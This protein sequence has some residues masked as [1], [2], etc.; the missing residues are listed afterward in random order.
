[1]QGMPSYDRAPPLWLPLPFLLVAPA[2]LGLAGAAL[3][4]AGAGTP[5]RFDP[6]LLAAT[7]LLALGVLGNA[8]CGSA[9]QIMAV[10]AGVSYARPQGLFRSLFWPLQLGCGALAWAFLA[11]FSAPAFIMA[12]AC[13]AYAL[14]GIAARGLAGLARSPSRD[15]TRRGMVVALLSLA[16]VVGLGLALIG[17]LAAAW[18]LP[19]RRLLDLHVLF[20]LGGWLLGL[21]MAVAVTVVPMF[22]IT[23]PYP[24]GWLRWAAWAWL[25]ALLMAACG[26]WLERWPLL[27]PAG[28]LA[29]AF[30]WLTWRLQARSRR[31]QDIGRRFWRWAMAALALSLVMAIAGIVGGA[32]PGLAEA[33]GGLALFGLGGGVVLGMWYKIVPFLLWLDLQKRAPRGKRA[34]SSLQLLPE[35]AHRRC[36]ALYGIA[37]GLGAAAV[38]GG[39]PTAAP[40][41]AAM[42]LATC[43]CGDGAA[44]MRRYRICRR[45][46]TAASAQLGADTP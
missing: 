20:A 27:L 23:P 25:A 19:W 10:V 6:A 18:P 36:L 2:W 7:H 45:C 15:A 42:V 16:I 11:G 14:L 22:Q 31:P 1:M 43:W 4:L 33:A 46:W 32:A 44:A 40:G 17:T 41:V 3:M 30:A 35:S 21:I 29:A 24:A 28:G 37:L 5:Q 8:M 39:A 34:P 9:L 26:L 38:L 12:G 13:L